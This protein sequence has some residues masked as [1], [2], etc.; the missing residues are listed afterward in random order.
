V[1]EDDRHMLMTVLAGAAG[2][3]SGLVAWHRSRRSCSAALSRWS[4]L[5]MPVAGA[6]AGVAVSL[7]AADLAV[8]IVA[9]HLV[10]VALPLAVID[11]LTGK[12]PR[13]Q[14]LATYP[15]TA[16]VLVVASSWTGPTTL[17]R[18]AAGAVM[19]WA[20][21]LAL[22]YLGQLG[23]GD[24]RLAPVLGAHLGHAGIL[25]VIIGVGAAFALGAVTTAVLA[26]A[27]RLGPDRRVPFAPALV[28]G[29][30]AALLG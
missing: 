1:A 2:G 14:V 20:V 4:T 15:T 18:A 27:G 22:A 3:S 29:S 21:F 8:M 19:L 9:L 23:A 12:L 17:L 24:V 6:L 16:L 28:G 30:V 26:A 5:A 13:R 25:T 7:S 11:A 10:V